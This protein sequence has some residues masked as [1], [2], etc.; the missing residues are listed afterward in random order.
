[1]L[2]GKHQLDVEI[3]NSI[4]HNSDVIINLLYPQVHDH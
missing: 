4:V 1:M 3:I 2:T